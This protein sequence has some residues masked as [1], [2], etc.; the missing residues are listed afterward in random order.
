MNTVVSNTSPLRYLVV[1]GEHALLAQLFSKIL[2]PNAVFQELTNERTPETVRQVMQSSPPWIEVHR[3]GE[4]RDPT[5]DHLDVGEQEAI[6]LTKH[7]Q[8]D[9]LLMDEK[10]GRFT[11]LER[12]IKVAGTLGILEL[13]A[14]Q[15]PIDLPHILHKLLQTNFKV[16]PSLIEAFL[17]RHERRT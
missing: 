7:V 16:S 14:R 10:K 12:G 9:L 13:A 1:I 4:M 3:V 5:L 15:Y 6:L 8:A 2:I 11:A 17:K